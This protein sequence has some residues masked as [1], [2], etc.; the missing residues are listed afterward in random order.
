MLLKSSVGGAIIL[1]LTE[2]P[3]VDD[4]VVASFLKQRWCDPGL[5]ERRPRGSQQA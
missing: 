5:E 1:I 2:R 3:L 4:R